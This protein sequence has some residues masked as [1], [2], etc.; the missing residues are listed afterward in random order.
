M[1]G[2]CTN[3]IE[4]LVSP[5]GL[6]PRCRIAEPTLHSKKNYTMLHVN[7]QIS[8]PENEFRFS[9]AR[10]PGPGGQNVNK[11]NTKAILHWSVTETKRLPEGV[12]RRLM[13]QQ[14]NRISDNGDLVISSHRFRDQKRNVA[15]CL[16]KLKTMILAVAQP[17]R[18]RKR[19][20]VPRAAKERRLENKRQKSQK[21]Q[22]RQ[23]VDRPY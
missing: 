8:I 1:T 2:F 4:I 12:R 23:R 5:S 9:Y 17:P 10:S 7:N 22:L 13:V 3:L 11:V 6:I 16:D 19:T 21:K 18:K 15:D 20:K 14:K